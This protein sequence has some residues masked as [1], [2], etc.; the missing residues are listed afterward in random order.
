MS[1]HR[2]AVRCGEPGNLV[3][4]PGL[5]EAG[6]LLGIRVLDSLIIGAGNAIYS[7]VDAGRW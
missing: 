7:F 5:R 2:V 1:G 6:E 3:G 4:V